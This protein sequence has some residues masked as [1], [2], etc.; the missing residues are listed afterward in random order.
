MA[1]RV[2]EVDAESAMME[3]E[4][5]FVRAARALLRPASSAFEWRE[6]QLEEGREDT[7]GQTVMRNTKGSRREFPRACAAVRLGEMRGPMPDIGTKGTRHEDRETALETR[8]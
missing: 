6:G 2:S 7:R 8:R 3:R 4:C 1:C 5:E